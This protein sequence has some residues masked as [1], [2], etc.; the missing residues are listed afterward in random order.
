MFA[1]LRRRSEVRATP[2]RRHD[3]RPRLEALEDR[4]VPARVW[5]VHSGL[6]DVNLHGTLRY[7][8]AHA[9]DGDTIRIAADVRTIDL[10]QG[11]LVIDKHLT[12][13]AVRLPDEA[14]DRA[15]S[16]HT[17]TFL[18][19]R[20][21]R[22]ALVT[23][24][25]SLMLDFAG[26]SPAMIQGWDGTANPRDDPSVTAYDGE[27]GA[28]L[29]FGTVVLNNC[30]FDNNSAAA[31]GGAIA[32]FGLLT[33]NDCTFSHNH[34]DAGGAIANFGTMDIHNSILDSNSAFTVGQIRGIGGV[35]GTV[36]TGGGPPVFDVFPVVFGRL[37]RAGLMTAVKNFH[38][39]PT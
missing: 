32:N 10:T 5:A 1:L 34:S 6:D 22:F 26:Q 39:S 28:I 14:S 35:G 8:L 11:E 16:I 29:N 9:A 36:G 3:F 12:I 19:S 38:P 21:P 17:V 25:G 30:E 20:D 13:D 24:T 4:C 27:G 15:D 7:A 33:V 18:S 2:A 31:V 23:S 37:A